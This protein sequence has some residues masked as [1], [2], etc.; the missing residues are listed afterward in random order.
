MRSAA[1]A[2]RREITAA[3]ESHSPVSTVF[4]DRVAGGQKI[5]PARRPA[6]TPRRGAIGYSVTTNLIPRTFYGADS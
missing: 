1:A 5:H 4:C 2:K 3:G 6:K